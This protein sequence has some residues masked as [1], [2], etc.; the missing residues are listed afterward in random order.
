MRAG[1][2]FGDGEPRV[3]VSG[4]RELVA[5]FAGFSAVSVEARHLPTNR[6]SPRMRP[7]A[8]RVLRPL[9]RRI[10]WYWMVDALG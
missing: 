2:E 3:L 7:S 6:L 5:T 10:G 4:R 8:D 9:E 1:F